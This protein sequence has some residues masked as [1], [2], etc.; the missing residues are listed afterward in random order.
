MNDKEKQLKKGYI[1]KKIKMTKAHFNKQLLIRIQNV[2]ELEV[3]FFL[4]SVAI[5][6]F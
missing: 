2:E 5:I 1:E 6:H 4:F 3:N